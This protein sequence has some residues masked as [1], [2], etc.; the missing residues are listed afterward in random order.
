MSSKLELRPWPVE[1]L[2]VE[3]LVEGFGKV[4]EFDIV[5]VM[6]VVVELAAIDV[7]LFAVKLVG[8]IVEQLRLLL[9]V[10]VVVVAAADV[11][12][13]AVVG[14]VASGPQ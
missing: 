13:V 14:A 8:V 5:V 7:A 4:D 6:F 1:L 10:V 3:V 12:V 11:V 2:V 9:H